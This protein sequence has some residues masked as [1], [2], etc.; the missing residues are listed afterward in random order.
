MGPVWL[1]NVS[2]NLW[3]RRLGEGKE[4]QSQSKQ[5]TP[6]CLQHL[7]VLRRDTWASWP[8]QFLVA[9]EPVDHL[10]ERLADSFPLTQS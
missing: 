9:L 10:Y 3:G 2:E 7:L 5:T 6:L 8:L 4:D 1:D